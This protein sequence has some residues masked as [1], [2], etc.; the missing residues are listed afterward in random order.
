MSLLYVPW[1]GR[2]LGQLNASRFRQKLLVIIPWVSRWLVA[3][4]QM[5][6]V[7]PLPGLSFMDT[8]EYCSLA[9]GL[10]IYVPKFPNFFDFFFQISTT[11]VDLKLN[12]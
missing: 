10:S 6:I 11:R 8:T 12:V 3:L 7:V 2:T 9:L 1:R 5:M 4:S